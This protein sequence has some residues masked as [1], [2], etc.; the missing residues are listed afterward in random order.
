MTISINK[1]LDF[2]PSEEDDL[3]GDT[4]NRKSRVIEM[5]DTTASALKAHLNF[6]NQNKLILNDVYRQ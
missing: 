5:A 1:S 3:F 2:Q 6:Q 4:K